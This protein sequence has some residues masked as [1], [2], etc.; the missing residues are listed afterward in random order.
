M[1]VPLPFEFIKKQVMK[2]VKRSHR[3]LAVIMGI[4][5][6]ATLVAQIIR[7]GRTIKMKIKNYQSNTK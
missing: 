1:P 6:L 4:A 7:D 5:V 3:V 2:L